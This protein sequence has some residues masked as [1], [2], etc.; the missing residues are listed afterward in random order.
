VVILPETTHLQR[1][2]G[3]RRAVHASW[4]VVAGTRNFHRWVGLTHKRII[5]TSIVDAI[6]YIIKYDATPVKLEPG[7]PSGCG[8]SECTLSKYVDAVVLLGTARG[9]EYPQSNCEFPNLEDDPSHVRFGHVFRRSIFYACRLL[10]FPKLV[11]VGSRAESIDEAELTGVRGVHINTEVARPYC[12]YFASDWD[13]KDFG[14]TSFDDVP[15]SD[16]SGQMKLMSVDYPMVA[17]NV[18]VLAGGGS[19]LPGAG[20]HWNSY[21]WFPDKTLTIVDPQEAA[22]ISIPDRFFRQIR[23]PFDLTVFKNRKRP[24]VYI[25]DIRSDPGEGNKDEMWYFKIWLEMKKMY[26]RVLFADVMR[27]TDRSCIAVSLKTRYSYFGRNTEF[28]EPLLQPNQASKSYETRQMFLLGVDCGRVRKEVDVERYRRGCEM[29]AVARHVDLGKNGDQDRFL[30]SIFIQRMNVKDIRDSTV[31]ALFSVSNT[32]NPYGLLSELASP[33]ANNAVIATVPTRRVMG[34]DL[35]PYRMRVERSAVGDPVL[36]TLRYKGGTFSDWIY[37]EVDLQKLGFNLFDIRDIVAKFTPLT[38]QIP[39]FWASTGVNGLHAFFSVWTVVVRGVRLWDYRIQDIYN[40][41]TLFVKVVP[42]RIRLVLGH[43]GDTLYALRRA[44][45]SEAGLLPVHSRAH[46]GYDPRTKRML[47]VS[48]H[49]A[50]ILLFAAVRCFDARRYVETL[51]FNLDLVRKTSY[52]MK[53]FRKHK[54]EFVERDVGVMWH[55]LLDYQLG[56]SYFSKIVKLLEWPEVE[57][58]A[59]FVLERLSRLSWPLS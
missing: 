29:W 1:L 11:F 19:S 34:M 39:N 4:S 54:D 27:D 56:E 52:A 46:S 35:A 32:S 33:K 49:L 45:V 13:E 14:G 38:S 30:K 9:G 12:A 41:Q 7:W 51:E 24:Y 17:L 37:D 23:A 26:V 5:F 10:R 6:E 31:V 18:D 58:L 48:G 50:D 2:L 16:Y 57:G 3:A 15:Y 28:S 53:L 20:T 8:G 36:V 40:S 22:D 43:T 59:H 42:E 25:D 44:V 55:S 47:S 21:H